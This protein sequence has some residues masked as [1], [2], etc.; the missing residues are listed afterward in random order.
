MLEET[1]ERVVGKLGDQV[2]R[3]RAAKGR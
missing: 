3:V 1:W 2:M